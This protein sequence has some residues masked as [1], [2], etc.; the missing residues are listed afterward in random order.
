V[1][2]EQAEPGDGF[3]ADVCVDWEAAAAAARPLG[4][5]VVCLRI[6]IV[7]A[8]EGGAL[9][10]MALPFRYGLGGPLGNGRQWVPWIHVDDVARL[11]A[12]AVEDDALAGP[13]NAV[14]PDP[15][16]NEVLT[17][18]LAHALRRPAFLR[19][20]AFALR[21]AL[22]HLS[23]ELLCSRRCVPRKAEDAGFVFRHAALETA[24]E[25]ELDP[26]GAG[27]TR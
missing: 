9:P 20:P 11:A 10:T 17:G 1:L 5:R 18:A 26:P 7:L 27:G 2:D 12:R 21:L 25:A 16:R 13:V 14:A 8:R 6:G 4:V 23:G 15:V 24:L 3:L 22:G 19:A